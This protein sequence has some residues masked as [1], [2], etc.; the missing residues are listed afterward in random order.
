VLVS[1][2]QVVDEVGDAGQRAAHVLRRLLCHVPRRLLRR[3]HIYRAAAAH[4]TLQQVI[5][6]LIVMNLIHYW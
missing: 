3:R 4:P 2:G 1:G 6:I 5:V